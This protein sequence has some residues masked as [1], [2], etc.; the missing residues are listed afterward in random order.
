M[1]FFY[2]AD[3]ILSRTATNKNHHSPLFAG[4]IFQKVARQRISWDFCLRTSCPG[5]IVAG[6]P[7]Y[8]SQ[9]WKN[10]NNK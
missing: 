7:N 6:F 2:A 8:L 10:Q 9:K 4:K 1:V 5:A 3:V